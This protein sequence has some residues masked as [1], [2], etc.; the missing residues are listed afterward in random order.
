MVH[1]KAVPWRSITV[2]SKEQLVSFGAFWKV[3]DHM[4]TGQL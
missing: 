2:A 4:L 3:M 1:R